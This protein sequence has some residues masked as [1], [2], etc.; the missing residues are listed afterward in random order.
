ME[1]PWATELEGW[2]S[3]TPDWEPC[4]F[5]RPVVSATESRISYLRDG[6]V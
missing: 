3:W 6:V 1:S 5:S 4:S 2:L